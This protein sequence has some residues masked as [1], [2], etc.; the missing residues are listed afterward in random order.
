M[1]DLL[2]LYCL[3]FIFLFLLWLPIWRIKL[4]I[5]DFMAAK[6]ETS[7]FTHPRDIRG[8]QKSK[9]LCTWPLLTQF[10]IFSLVLTAIHLC[11]KFEISSFYHVLEIL[12]GPKIPKVGLVTRT[13]P[14]LTKF[15]NFSLVLTAIHLCAEFE[16]YSFSRSGDIRGPKNPKVGHVTFT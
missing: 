16:V 8:S 6:F 3:L 14:L 9:I 4:Y 1:S 2:G 15:C 12:G 7:S 13:W 5:S 11:A 10:C